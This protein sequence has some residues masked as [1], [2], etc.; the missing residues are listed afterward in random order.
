MVAKKLATVF[1]LE[2][3]GRKGIHI[4]HSVLGTAMFKQCSHRNTPIGMPPIPRMAVNLF[5]SLQ[6]L[7][8][9]GGVEMSKNKGRGR[10]GRNGMQRAEPCLDPSALWGGA[11][12]PQPQC[13]TRPPS[14]TQQQL[15]V[16]EITPLRSD[17]SAMG[18][19]VQVFHAA[20]PHCLWHPLHLSIPTT[21][22]L[23]LWQRGVFNCPFTTLGMPF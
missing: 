22:S 12:S 4:L 8:D 18:G 13:F 23:H 15:P 21:P 9:M 10:E 2:H 16:P 14:V 6:P 1:H 3:T 11:M 19:N 5:E 20:A 7:K 17:T